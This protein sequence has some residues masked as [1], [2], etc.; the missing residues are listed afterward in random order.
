MGGLHSKDFLL[1][2]KLVLN[3]GIKCDHV[4]LNQLILVTW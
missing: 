4:S 2:L 1:K 3:Q